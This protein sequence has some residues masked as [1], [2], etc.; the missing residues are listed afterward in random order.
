MTAG[1]V[2]THDADPLAAALAYA[3][4]GLRVLPIVPGKKHPPISAWQTA[5]TT[6]PGTIEAWWTGPYS[7]HGVG[8][9]TGAGSGIWVLDIDDYDAYRDLDTPLVQSLFDNVFE[10]QPQNIFLVK[11]TY[12]FLL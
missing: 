4:R 1:P 9:A 10:K 5:A 6:D 3:A 12:R 8:I 2:P 7:G 11:F